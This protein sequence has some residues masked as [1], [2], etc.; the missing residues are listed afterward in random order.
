[1]QNEAK[2]LWIKWIRVEYLK[3]KDTWTW[4]PSDR[5]PVLMRHFASIRDAIVDKA[6]GNVEVVKRLLGQWFTLSNSTSGV[7]NWLR[8][9]NEKKLWHS[10]IWKPYVPQK[11]IFYLW[12]AIRER[13]QTRNQLNYLNIDPERNLSIFEG[14]VFKPGELVAK[15][16]TQLYMHLCALS[17]HEKIVGDPAT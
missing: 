5:D 16:K 1:M 17:P 11:Y 9:K 10:F 14:K 12:M 6:N 8:S 7:Y 4:I 3:G 15:I 2:S 13:L